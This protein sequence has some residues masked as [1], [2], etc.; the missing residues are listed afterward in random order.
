[1]KEL[2]Q[3]FFALFAK[4][5][6]KVGLFQ[7]IRRKLIHIYELYGSYLPA[8][9][10]VGGFSFDLVTLGRIDHWVTLFQQAVFLL[11][12]G[13]LLAIETTASFQSDARPAWLVKT[14]PYRAA[15]LHFLFGGLLSAYTI[16]YFKSA[17]TLPSFFFMLML[18]ALLILNEHSALQKRGLAVKYVLFSLCLLSYFAYLVPMLWGEIGSLP[19]VVALLSSLLLLLVFLW[20]AT[21]E[22]EWVPAV[23]KRY[24]R[25]PLGVHLI[26]ASFYFLGWLPP[27]PLS[28]EYAGVYHK[29]SRVG[30]VFQLEYDRPFWRFWENGAQT[31]K[32]RPEDRVQCFARIFSPTGLTDRITAHWMLKDPKRGWLTTDRIPIEVTGGRQEGF[33]GVTYK[34]NYQPGYYRVLFETSD[35]RELGRVYFTVE[36]DRDTSERKYRLDTA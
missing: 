33:R 9:F 32:A 17:S 14:Q 25:L 28:L 31:F 6:T 20:S 23:V 24:L 1:M 21:P 11:L 12:I 13:G 19:F 7:L 5:T 10:F 36:L 4:T 15:L 35:G 30:G 22:K 18:V 16:F 34:K 26:F 29:I 8:L 2:F 3:A 27:A